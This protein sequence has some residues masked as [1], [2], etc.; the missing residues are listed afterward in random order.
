MMGT[1]KVSVIVVVFVYGNFVRRTTMMMTVKKMVLIM[2]TLLSNNKY[3]N[4]ELIYNATF[5]F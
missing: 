5:V 1:S 4:C 2:E 3:V